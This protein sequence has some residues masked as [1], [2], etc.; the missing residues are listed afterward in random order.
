MKYQNPIITGFY[1]DPSMIRVKNH[2]YIVNSSFEY[3]PGIPLFHSTDLLNWEQLT[4]VLHRPEQLEIKDTKCSG[5]IYAPTIRYNQGWY[6][7]VATNVSK[8]NLLVKSK[9]PDKDWSTPIYLQQIKGLDPSLYFE[10]GR[11]YLQYAGF[12][13][14]FKQQAIR[15]VEI[16][17][18]T[19]QNIGEDKI[20]SFGCGGRDVEGPHI[21]KIGA[22]YYL[23]CA[24]GGTREGHMVTLQR[25][26][27]L[28]GPY[29]A[30]PHNP[31][32]SN[33]NVAH[34][35]QAV[36]HGDIVQDEKGHWWMVALA[37]REVKHKHVLGRETI[38]VPLVW[39]DD[40]FYVEGGI[41][42]EEIETSLL[43]Q[44]QKQLHGFY[45][46]F[47]STELEHH[48][49]SLRESIEERITIQPH[50][51][52]MEGNETT[53]HD[54]AS[55]SFLC[56]RQKAWEGCF[57]TNLNVMDSEECGIAIYMDPCHHMEFGLRKDT[58][59]YNLIVRKNV[60]EISYLDINIPWKSNEV[61]LQIQCDE[62][63]Y[64]FLYQQGDDF[65]EVTSTRCKHLATEVADASF[66][67]V[68]VGI[69]VYGNGKKA[70]CT[71]FR[72]TYE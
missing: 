16:D 18:A 7:I 68:M 11:A 3:Y 29:E 57:E 27:S 19:G 28:W 24:E 72:Y 14:D 5:G 34:G 45:D 13:D 53:L 12:T 52:V 33:R 67:G 44:E 1:P 48:W 61:T 63:N 71:Y 20:I 32:L 40:W 62:E 55:P 22:Y 43:Y 8:G 38:L 26:T 35:L 46:T 36:G 54:S 50:A 6:Y 47:T 2:Y 21:Y 66:N 69:Y 49:C 64:H 9:H 59:Q 58:D 23:L 17:L 60:G 4:Y 51:F 15:M 25:A 70:K 31:I 42:L 37:Q 39:E 30:Y 65:V 41:A 10:D 56:T